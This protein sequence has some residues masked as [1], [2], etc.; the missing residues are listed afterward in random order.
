MSESP[1]RLN[2]IEFNRLEGEQSCRIALH[3]TSL[4]RVLICLFYFA[5]AC[6]WHSCQLGQRFKSHRTLTP[7]K[8]GFVCQK[9]TGGLTKA[10]WRFDWEKASDGQQFYPLIVVHLHQKVAFKLPFLGGILMKTN[11]PMGLHGDTP[12][13]LEQL[14]NLITEIQSG[15]NPLYTIVIYSQYSLGEVQRALAS[16][17]SPERGGKREGLQLTKFVMVK[18]S[19]RLSK[20]SVQ[21]NPQQNNW[22]HAGLSARR[23]VGARLQPVNPHGTGGTGSAP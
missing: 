17:N 4:L 23:P 20:C 6:R 11:P 10:Y 12:W 22:C 19:H 5:A 16:S 14:R 7:E 8:T 9:L 13:S 2:R 18:V 1:S 15:F 3:C 21:L